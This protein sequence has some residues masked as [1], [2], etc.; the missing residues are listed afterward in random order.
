MNDEIEIRG[1]R[2]VLRPLRSAEIDEEWRAMVTG[3]PIAIGT[4]P[5]ETTFRARLARSGQMRDGW[6]DLAVDLGGE[7]IGRIQTYIPP[8]RPIPPGTFSIGISL[9]EGARGN[10]YGREALSLFT[11]WLFGHA[12]ARLLE[13]GTDQANHAMRAVFRHVGWHEDGV[14]TEIGRDWV[15]Y[16]IT[17][18]DWEAR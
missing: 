18:A 8:G 16:R 12:G 1:E 15:M 7:A 6:L 10:G 9:H 17:R 5:D 14:L 3:D 11:D 13:A 2:L 4:L